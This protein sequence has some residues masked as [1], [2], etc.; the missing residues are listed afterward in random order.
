MTATIFI[1]LGHLTHADSQ[2][3]WAA[4]ISTT[5]ERKEMSA[6]PRYA[7]EGC[8]PKESHY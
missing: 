2:Q 1:D 4:P 3:E 7:P 8:G 6:H 5:D